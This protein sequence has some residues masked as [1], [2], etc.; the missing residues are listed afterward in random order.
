VL[1]SDDIAAT[2]AICEMKNRLI[3]KPVLADKH[4]K[5]IGELCSQTTIA[6]ASG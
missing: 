3:T 2:G 5:T 4:F 6:A 1:I